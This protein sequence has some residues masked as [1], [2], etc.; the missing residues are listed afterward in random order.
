MEATIK[1]G[2]IILPLYYSIED[3]GGINIDTDSIMEE[4][5]KI[6]DLI[7]TNNYIINETELIDERLE[8]ENFK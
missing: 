4:Y 3:D 8:I 2:K 1:N 6:M 7:N 5:N